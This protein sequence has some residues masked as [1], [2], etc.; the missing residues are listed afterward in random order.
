MRPGHRRKTDRERHNLALFDKAIWSY[1][2]AGVDTYTQRMAY[3]VP[4]VTV[5]KVASAGGDCAK[6]DWAKAVSPVKSW[7][8][9]NSDQPTRRALSLLMAHDGQY[10]YLKFI[11]PCDVSKLGNGYNGDTLELFTANGRANPYRQ[12]IAFSARRRGLRPFFRVKSIGGWECRLR[13]TTS[14]M[15]WFVP[16]RTRRRCCW[17]CRS[18]R[19]CRAE[20]RSNRATS[21]T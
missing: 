17:P 6:V 10:L 19:S 14:G 3:P 4:S 9:Q 20:N 8:R 21:S 11:D 2:K 5:P 1:M 7:S 18:T 13:T 12:F 15:T 16:T